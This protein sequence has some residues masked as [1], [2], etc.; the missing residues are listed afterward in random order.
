MAEKRVLMI[1]K[2]D[3]VWEKIEE[4]HKYWEEKSLPVWE[5]NGANHIGSFVGYLGG[6]KNQIVRLFEFKSIS[7]WDKFMQRR[8]KRWETELGQE[9]LRNLFPYLEKIEETVWISAYD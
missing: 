6:Q 7:A 2:V 3:A 4:F 8:Q 9:S 5:E 1:T